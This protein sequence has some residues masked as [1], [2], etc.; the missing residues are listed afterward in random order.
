MDLP[1]RRLSH[2]DARKSVNVQSRRLDY[3]E[4]VGIGR[5]KVGAVQNIE[6]LGDFPNVVVLEYRDIRIQQAGADERVASYV[7]ANIKARVGKG[8][9][10]VAGERVGGGERH[11]PKAIRFQVLVRVYHVDGRAVRTRPRPH[12]E[13]PRIDARVD[14]PSISEPS[15]R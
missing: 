3:L 14:F 13:L 6:D 8:A 10:G 11:Q 1:R 9:R 12:I 5:A 4:A 15:E 7:A 2:R